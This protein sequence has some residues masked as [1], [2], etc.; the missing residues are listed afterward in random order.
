MRIDLLGKRICADDI[1]SAYCELGAELPIDI[2]R[3]LSEIEENCI[4]DLLYFNITLI[5]PGGTIYV[6]ARDFDLIVE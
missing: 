4:G 3:M 5:H 1:A 6:L 2:R